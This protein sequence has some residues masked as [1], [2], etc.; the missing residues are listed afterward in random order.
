[1]T[2]RF[3]HFVYDSPERDEIPN[4]NL[5]L[6]LHYRLTIVPR[7][8]DLRAHNSALITQ[9]NRLMYKS[10]FIDNSLIISPCSSVFCVSVRIFVH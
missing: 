4:K 8:F 1:M 2:T 6:L 5:R 9:N 7:G 10:Y 3:I